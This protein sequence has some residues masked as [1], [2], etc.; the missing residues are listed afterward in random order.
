MAMI[1]P[2]RRAWGAFLAGAVLLGFAPVAGLAVDAAALLLLALDAFLARPLRREELEIE[3]PSR[4]AQGDAARVRLH[5]RN[6]TGR[7]LSLE[8]ALDVPPLLAGSGA[9][10]AQRLDVADGGSASAEVLLDA[11]ARG[12]HDFGAVHYRVLGPLRMAW[13]QDSL[14]GPDPVQV[15]PGLREVRS[16]RLL[17]IHHQ[18]HQSGVR[19]VRLSGAGGVF[20]SLREYV[21][22]DDPRRVDWKASGRRGTVIVRE[23]EAE[24]SQNII[25]CI[26]TGRLM[27]GEAS[28]E[29]RLDRAL[30]AVLV[31][32]EV[33]RVW[34]D[35]VGVFAFSDRVNAALPPG[36]HSPDKI[37]QILGA[38][39]ARSVEP[40]YP[41]AL[42][43]LSRFAKRRSLLVFFGDVIDDEVSGPFTT[44]LAR[45]ARRHVPLFMALR[46]TELFLATTAPAV[47]APAACRR[48]A[49]TELVLARARSLARLRERGVLVADV[50][51]AGA[52]TAVV[53]RYIEIKRRGVL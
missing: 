8:V 53:N 6:R 50:D 22:G 19:N 1:L 21:R 35:H 42:T 12:A 24:R 39:V 5:V 3:A 41:R 36:R 30:A 40:D 47:D 29:G 23:Y 17:A 52:V 48:A 16:H 11:R 20:E 46:S 9:A 37:P 43:Q 51:P 31:L 7:R 2:S 28:G 14:P 25:L 34:N 32:A 15:I 38:L 10:R 18:L 45:L 27:A 49:A 26:D 4:L 33:A 44:Q 13:R